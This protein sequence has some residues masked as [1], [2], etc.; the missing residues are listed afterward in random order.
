MSSQSGT[1]AG[2]FVRGA[3]RRGIRFSKVISYGNAADIDESELLEY[4]AD[5]AESEIVTCYIE[6]VKDGRRFFQAL[7]RAAAAKPVLVLKGGRTESGQRATMSHTGSLAGSAEVF[8][9]LCRQAGALQVRSLDEMIDLA[10]AFRFGGAV[11]GKRVALVAGG[12]GISVAAAD[13]IDDAGLLCPALPEATQQKLLEFIPAAGSSVRN[14]I[15]AFVS[16][17][18]TRLGDTVRIAGEA[19]NI[20]AVMV[21]MD[22]TSPG[23]AMSPAAAEPDKAIAALVD[24]IV[25]A[26]AASGKPPIIV[27]QERMDV[28]SVRH[29]AIFQEKCWQAGMPVYPTAGRAAAATARLLEWRRR[30]SGQA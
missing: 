6:G 12:G 18:P 13:E 24:A 22:F 20:D 5:D 7:K 17:D 26:S 8:A 11:G 19:E 2:E 30:R 4:L 28:D 27:S 23:F 1:N 10:V 15:D 25:Q 14:P 21:Q 3:S 29:T 16:F 9:A